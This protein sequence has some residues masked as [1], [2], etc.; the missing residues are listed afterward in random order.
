[1]AVQFFVVQSYLQIVL[2]T[3]SLYALHA[4]GSPVQE[5]SDRILCPLGWFHYQRFCLTKAMGKSDRA[6]ALYCDG[7]GGIGIKG[8]CIIRAQTEVSEKELLGDNYQF[9]SDFSLLGGDLAEELKS[10]PSQADDPRD[11][12]TSTLVSSSAEG[13]ENETRLCPRGW[14]HYRSLCLYKPESVEERCRNLGAVEFSG[15]CLKHADTRALQ[16]SQIDAESLNKRI[17]CCSHPKAK[18]NNY[19]C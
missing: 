8:L 4:Y 18:G 3:L 1:M 9:S 17:C 14:S 2:T 5:S 11:E 13:S 10:F 19:G 15:L 12:S 7:F 6:V 16:E